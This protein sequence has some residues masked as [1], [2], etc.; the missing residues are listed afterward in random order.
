VTT[1][2]DRP[3]AETT[4]EADK[5]G[6][7]A[8]AGTGDDTAIRALI[9]SAVASAPGADDVDAQRDPVI[10]PADSRPVRGRSG[11]RGAAKPARFALRRVPVDQASRWRMRV[12]AAMFMTQWA[13]GVAAGVGF[14]YF[15]ADTGRDEFRFVAILLSSVATFICSV[16]ASVE[17]SK[18]TRAGRSVTLGLAVFNAVFAVVAAIIAQHATLALSQ[19][20]FAVGIALFLATPTA[21]RRESGPEQPR[22]RRRVVAILLGGLIV[23]GAWVVAIWPAVEWQAMQARADAAFADVA[24]LPPG[25]VAPATALEAADLQARVAQVGEFVGATVATKARAR[26]RAGYAY[27]LAGDVDR[28]WDLLNRG[29]N[30]LDPDRF[31]TGAATTERLLKGIV[32]RLR[33]GLPLPAEPPTGSPT[34][35]VPPSED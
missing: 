32:F 9:R 5:A 10:D 33:S 20:V 28:G 34:A 8:R 2:P 7:G 11:R 26:C 1:D 14:G 16:V 6:D 23:L 13:V 21:E 3:E 22:P 27:A 19:V 17:L 18:F 24:A 35:D 30:A 12:G 29:L 15:A 31:G 25:E 4:S